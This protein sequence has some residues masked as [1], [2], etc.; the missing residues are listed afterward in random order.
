MQWRSFDNVTLY[1][2]RN[3]RLSNI[4]RCKAILHDLLCWYDL[5]ITLWIVDEYLK[6][7]LIHE[8]ECFIIFETRGAAER[9]RYD[10]HDCSSVLNDFKY[11]AL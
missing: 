8:K 7:Y 11:A 2:R 1:H 4:N 9:F 5:P 10:K 3:E 6:Y